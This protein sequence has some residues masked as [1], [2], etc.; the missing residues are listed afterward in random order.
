M[1]AF[2]AKSTLAFMLALLLNGCAMLSSLKPMPRTDGLYVKN[3]ATVMGLQ[4]D[5]YQFSS[6]IT[7]YKTTGHDMS[8]AEILAWT[9]QSKRRPFMYFRNGNKLHIYFHFESGKGYSEEDL[10]DSGAIAGSY[11]YSI[12][13]QAENATYNSDQNSLTL[14][15]KAENPPL[16]SKINVLSAVA[17]PLFSANVRNKTLLSHGMMILRYAD[18]YSLYDAEKNSEVLTASWIQNPADS[19]TLM[20]YT[21]TGFGVTDIKGQV[22]LPFQYRNMMYLGNNLYAVEQDG[23]WSVIRPDGTIVTALEPGVTI[24]G[25]LLA[26]TLLPLRKQGKSLYYSL[27]EKRYLDI[28]PIQTDKVLSSDKFFKLRLPKGTLIIRSNGERALPLYVKS[29]YHAHGLLIASDKAGKS[30]IFDEQGQMLAGPING[31]ISPLFSNDYSIRPNRSPL[32]VL[33]VNHR[34]GLIDTRGNIL[35]PP[36]YSSILYLG[37]DH[38][39]LKS[40]SA[41]GTRIYR[42]DAGIVPQDIS[43][44]N[45]LDG[46][47]IIVNSALTDKYGLWDTEAVSWVVKPDR[48]DLLSAGLNSRYLT[49]LVS[50]GAKQNYGVIDRNGK[51]LHPP[52]LS[53][54]TA[55]SGDYLYNR[56]GSRLVL[57]TLPGMTK[58]A[59]VDGS[60]VSLLDDGRYFVVTDSL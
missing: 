6:D 56:Q 12:P 9:Q 60:S 42:Q 34:K 30:A 20:V 32:L 59:E 31:V 13:A 57:Y 45:Y 33:E 46:R 53:G 19:D 36:D 27:S 21:Q 43:D 22:L 5:V 1:N 38:F 47:L 7:L 23:L 52:E 51:E 10:T 26:G 49:T 24:A 29:A 15:S 28:P 25:S 35:I 3:T 55:I 11:F 54:Y 50:Q 2:A 8:D 16:K 44:A 4:R 17:E 18:Y 37:N 41:T 14:V 40:S 48:F 39:L 58:I